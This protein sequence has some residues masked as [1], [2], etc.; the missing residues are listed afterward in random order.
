[1]YIGRFVILGRTPE[2]APYLGYRVS[3]RSFPNRVIRTA[4]DR[5]MVVPTADA[6]PS[7]NP[8]ISYNCLRT[9]AAPQGGRIT[10]VANGSH[11]DP[12][13]DKIGLGY[14]LRDAMALSLLAMDYEHDDYSTPRIAAGV[15]A[16][17]DGFL[18]LV[19]A[20][21][22]LVQQIEVAAGEAY[23]IATYERTDPTPIAL[24]GSTP[25]ALCDA[26]F[27]CEYELPVAALIA[28]PS[29]DALHMAV[30]SAR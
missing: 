27:T 1:M 2:G 25:E 23:L 26:L 14:P 4:D 3:S 24:A 28:M 17:S 21:K 7:D 8:Y 30:R 29:D 11:V 5:A 13:I 22:L 12:I 6:P 16:G 15:D 19:G 18:A 20:N 9:A 10:V